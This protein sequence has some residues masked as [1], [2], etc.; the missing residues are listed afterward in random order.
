MFRHRDRPLG[1]FGN[2]LPPDATGMPRLTGYPLGRTG[3]HVDTGARGTSTGT[4]D[5]EGRP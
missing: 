1:A 2:T 5:A 4:D 3:G